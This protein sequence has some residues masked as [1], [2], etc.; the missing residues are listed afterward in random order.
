MNARHANTFQVP[1]HS[2]FQCMLGSDTHV[3]KYKGMPKSANVLQ[4]VLMHAEECYG[5]LGKHK[6]ELGKNAW[7]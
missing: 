2:K 4:S 7:K 6:G 3:M 1:T 5:L